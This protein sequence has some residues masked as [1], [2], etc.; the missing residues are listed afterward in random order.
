[1]KIHKKHTQKK[2]LFHTKISSTLLDPLAFP[3]FWNYN[4]NNKDFF[5]PS[6]VNCKHSIKH[7]YILWKLVIHDKIQIKIIRGSLKKPLNLWPRAIPPGRGGQ[8]VGGH[9][10]KV[11][12]H[13]SNLFV[14][15][16]EALKNTLFSLVTPWINVSHIFQV[17]WL[18]RSHL[19]PNVCQKLFD[20]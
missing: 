12:F 8:R 5:H 4:I 9:S 11:F 3:L 2:P 1:M 15:L 14:C 20:S 13:A 7:K 10:H 17:I 18:P 19:S 16:Q 6:T